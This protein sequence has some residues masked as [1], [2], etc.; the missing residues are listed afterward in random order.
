MS[1]GP[2]FPFDLFEIGLKA[3]LVTLSGCQ[4]AAPGLDYGNSFS[5]AKSFLQAGS[6]FVLASL[7]QVSDKV[8]GEF[9]KKFYQELKNTNNIFDSYKMAV[10]EISLQYENPAF[11]SSFVLLGV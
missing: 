5:L 8:S 2:F 3:E 1:D 7:W 9:M 6:R 10:D 11:W 4:T